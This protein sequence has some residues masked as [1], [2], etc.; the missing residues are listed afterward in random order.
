ML[1]LLFKFLGALYWSQIYQEFAGRLNDDSTEQDLAEVLD[2]IMA[3]VK[4][5]HGGVYG[6]LSGE[7]FYIY[8]EPRQGH[9][10]RIIKAFERQ[11]NFDDLSS[12]Y[13]EIR[14]TC[15]EVLQGYIAE[16]SEVNSPFNENI[17]WSNFNGDVGYMLIEAM[18]EIFQDESELKDVSIEQEKQAIDT[19]MASDIADLEQTNGLIIDLRF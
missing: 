15:F 16:G 7:P 11:N 17:I 19:I 1:I 14:S 6:E 8:Y 5:G 3:Q 9:A 18:D 10:H 12:Y 4:D 2:E 13:H